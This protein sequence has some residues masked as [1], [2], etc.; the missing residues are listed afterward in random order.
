MPTALSLL[1][2]CYPHPCVL[3][4]RPFLLRHRPFL[5]RWRGR[6]EHWHLGEFTR[7]AMPLIAGSSTGAGRC[8]SAVPHNCS[9]N[10]PK[11]EIWGTLWY[12][13]VSLSCEEK[14]I[15]SVWGIYLSCPVLKNEN[16]KDIQSRDASLKW[17]GI[18]LVMPRRPIYT[19]EFVSRLT[20]VMLI[21]HHFYIHHKL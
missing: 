14:P 3:P 21:N 2:Q 7:S 4:P 10:I 5:I 9:N 16:D 12:W 17:Q 13:Y 11:M 20:T 6:Y 15:I 19:E 1:P 8:I 18:T